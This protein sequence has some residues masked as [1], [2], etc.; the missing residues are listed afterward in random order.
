MYD[1]ELAAKEELISNLAED[2]QFLE[3][4]NDELRNENSELLKMFRELYG[5]ILP[6]YEG[7]PPVDVALGE[8]KER[9][10]ELQKSNIS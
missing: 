4:R 6:D 10:K 2:I 8:M 5:L 3:Y 7:P 1:D 9:I